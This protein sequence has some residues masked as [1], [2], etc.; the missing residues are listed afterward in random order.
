M[1]WFER[2]QRR[3]A[4][5][6]AALDALL[7]EGWVKSVH[8]VVD[9]DAGKAHVD[10]DFEG[11]GRLREARLEF[12]FIYPG[13]PP[14]LVPRGERQRW[15][16][17]QWD[18][19]GELCLQIRA[20]TWVKSFDAADVMRSARHLL[21][22]EGTL[23]DAGRAGEVPS[24]HRFTEGQ[25]LRWKYARL[26]LS[27]D[28]LAEVRRRGP[29]VWILDLRTT[30]FENSCI[31]FGV[32]IGGNEQ[33]ERWNDPTV[34]DSVGRAQMGVGRIALVESDDPRFLAL[35]AEN[36]TTDERWAAFSAI[37]FDGYGIVVGVL[38]DQ[39][40]AK[41]LGGENHSHDIIKILMDKQQRCPTRNAA[42]AGKRVAVLG[43]GSMGSKVAS[44]LARMGVTE[45]FL[46]DSDV[47]KP[48]NLVRNELDWG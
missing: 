39:V 47:L 43:C 19:W 33:H 22:T 15:S 25:L 26:V 27:D 10:I 37:P 30:F 12:P 35:T 17:H 21:D 36:M 18:M 45:F 6:R 34:P 42:L 14:R 9:A 16:N 4:H 20:D 46:V 11:G 38:G 40:G 44:S 1:A 29:G 28:L 31:S 24:E 8:W 32:G 5:E 3:Y 23:N 48:G 2:R 41:F 13:A 7:Q